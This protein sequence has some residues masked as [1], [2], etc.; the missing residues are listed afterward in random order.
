MEQERKYFT[1][2]DGLT[3]FQKPIMAFTV[4]LMLFSLIGIFLT[5]IETS[6]N[7]FAPVDS[8]YAQGAE[9]MKETF[10]DSSQ[11]LI[12]LPG[13][14]NPA[15]LKKSARTAELIAALDDVGTV[16]S[17]LPAVMGNES[18]ETI[19][20]YLTRIPGT[21]GIAPFV[22][23]THDEIS[24]DYIVLRVQLSVTS[25]AGKVVNQIAALLNSE[26]P[27]A[28]LSGEPYLESEI[29]NY[30]LRI[31]LIIPPAA[32]ILM[33]GVFRL[34]IGSIRATALS[35]APAVMGAVITLGLLS[36]LKGSI[37]IMSVL[38]PVFIIVL[39]SA[40]GLHVTSHVM[41]R[42]GMGDDNRAAV[43]RTLH[44]VG[45]PIIMTTLT[46]AAG[47]LSLMTVNSPA[48]REMAVTASG[49]I[50][51]AGLVT[52]IIL[53][54]LLAHQKPLP[55]RTGEQPSRL[56]A[57][58]WKL[59]GLPVI[60]MAL[61]IIAVSVPGLMRLTADFSMIS[62]Y[63]PSTGVRQSLDIVTEATGGSLPVEILIEADRPYDKSTI[64]AVLTFQEHIEE[65]TGAGSIS[66]YSLLESVLSAQGLGN[67]LPPS[68][69]I[70]KN[71]INR[72]GNTDPEM[73]ANLFKPGAGETGYLRVFIN[74]PSLDTEI[75]ES[76]AAEAESL[77]KTEGITAHPAGSAFDIM[78]M[79][80]LIIPQQ[81]R[82]I[83]IALAAVLLLTSC[84]LKS[85]KLGFA[86][87]IPIAITLVGLFGVMG[88]FS[89]D[90]SIITSIMSGLTIGVG[91][92]YAI[93]YT[94]M[95]RF[96]QKRGSEAPA[97]EA[98]RF[99][100]TPVLANA[101]GLSIG[102]TVM[103]FSPLQIHTTLSLLMWVT[104]VLS[105][106]LSLVLLPTMLGRRERK[107]GVK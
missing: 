35:M 73:K 75:L 6:F 16:V 90:I 62:L 8:P 98:M 47:F 95:F 51:L 72:V 9:L 88:Y 7:L 89:I 2:T 42:L 60:L 103:L 11:L 65:R 13:G 18:D 41:D 3:R 79:N 64:D 5:K 36:W 20:R 61:I 46:T 48:I 93:H 77:S 58:L 54:L 63:K 76:V 92:D 56:A 69:D 59:K 74:L 27:G 24:Q 1:Y 52:W 55:A 102:F 49:G 78:E 96:L 85:L 21:G 23:Y 30:V 99:V 91:I 94:S 4:L 105:S 71:L 50:I 32:I 39:G 14:K 80:R 68:S 44:S 43:S 70:V 104:M 66:L 15:D 28:V 107:I 31:L 45:I 101:L 10:G 33:L 106:L 38:V 26:Y 84:S 19:T 82:S 97:E 25:T 86:A 53:P 34:R 57:G 87:L 40:D 12:L 22:T 67:S 81:L 37:S 83:L 29:F 100:A 17:P